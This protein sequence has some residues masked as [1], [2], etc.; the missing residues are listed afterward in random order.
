M[1]VW[2]CLSL[3]L[4]ILITDLSMHTFVEIFVCVNVYYDLLKMRVCVPVSARAHV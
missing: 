3:H 2:V 1:C 4:C